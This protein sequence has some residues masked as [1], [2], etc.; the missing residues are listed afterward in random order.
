ME[1]HF[2]SSSWLWDRQP[3]TQE[4]LFTSTELFYNFKIITV[5]V[6]F[7]LKLAESTINVWTV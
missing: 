3:C 4:A 5:V 6:L 2:Y 1:G 7:I